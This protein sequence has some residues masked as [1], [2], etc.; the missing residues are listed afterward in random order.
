MG[1][2]HLAELPRSRR[3]KHVVACL[4]SDASDEAVIAASVA[5]AERDLEKAARDPALAE[6]VR[7]LAMVPQKARSAAFGAELR[8]MGVNVPDAPHFGD[9]CV[10][11]GRSLER[12][13]RNDFAEV[14]R[15]ALLGTLV[16]RLQD[17]LPEVLA[18][19]A[20]R[21]RRAVAQLAEEAA[22]SVSARAFFARLS[23]DTLA[24]WLER[25]LSAQIGP[26]RRFATAPRPP[27]RAT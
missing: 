14:V 26:S 1:H 16:S 10:G 17:G 2:I 11:L 19:D 21:L 12:Y 25:T 8:A 4:E 27:D 23:A 20:E 9:L 15:R 5:A 18:V 24:Y 7:L 3:W 13:V 22:F 6:A